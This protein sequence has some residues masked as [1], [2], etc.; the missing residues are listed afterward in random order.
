MNE[1]T[2]KNVLA[3]SL[4]IVLEVEADKVI[5]EAPVKA[6]VDLVEDEVE[7]VETRDE[8]RGEVWKRNFQSARRQTL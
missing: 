3:S 1:K 5:G 7:E 8:S 6:L 2:N 4:R